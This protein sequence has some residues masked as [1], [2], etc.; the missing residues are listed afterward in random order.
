[1]IAITELEEHLINVGD[2]Y[3][4]PSTTLEITK[5]LVEEYGGNI[6]IGKHPKMGWFVLHDQGCGAG[7]VWKEN[8]EIS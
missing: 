1:M 8:Q 4:A 2:W 7:V 5:N 3:K 6:A